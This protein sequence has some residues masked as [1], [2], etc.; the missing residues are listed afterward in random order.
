MNYNIKIYVCPSASSN[1]LSQ[2]ASQA[3]GLI[4]LDVNE[5]ST[6]SVYGDIGFLNCKPI[7]IKLKPDAQPY[8]VHV[9]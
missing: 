3:L 7:S 2:C 5:T 8:S 1:L 4:K 9:A 6:D